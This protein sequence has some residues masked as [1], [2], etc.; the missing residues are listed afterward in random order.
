VECTRDSSVGITKKKTVC[1]PVYTTETEKVL[2]FEF[3]AN[4][5][6]RTAKDVTFLSKICSSDEETFYLREKVERPNIRRWGCEYP[7]VM[8]EHVRNSSKTNVLRALSCDK[9]Y[10]TFFFGENSS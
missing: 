7:H 10:G 6:D 4:M 5:M 9:V 8:V 2:R 1:S 3:W